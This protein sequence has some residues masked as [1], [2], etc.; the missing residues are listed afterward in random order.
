M[1]TALDSGQLVKEIIMWLELL[2]DEKSTLNKGFR[3]QFEQNPVYIEPNGFS[4]RVKA[5]ERKGFVL[6]DGEFYFEVLTTW[7]NVYRLESL[8]EDDLE[9]IYE[10]MVP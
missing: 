10:Q 5:I 9:A 7:G 6:L 8:C 2:D 4:Q 3:V 1:T